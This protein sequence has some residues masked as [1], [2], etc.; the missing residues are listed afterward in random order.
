M[1]YL[2]YK[3][4]DARPRRLELE[5]RSY[6]LGRS[7]KN[8]L[9]LPDLSLSRRHA[10]LR[11]SGDG[12]WVV[13]DLGSKNGTFVDG[14]RVEGRHNARPG[15]VV[16]L[17]GSV[18]VIACAPLVAREQ[19]A[20]RTS[21][22]DWFVAWSYAALTFWEALWRVAASDRDVGVLLLGEM[23]TGKDL[24]KNDR[25][26]DV[27]HVAKHG[28]ETGCAGD[29]DDGH[30]NRGLLLRAGLPPDLVGQLAQFVVESFV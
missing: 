1:A 17:S 14:Q 8:D 10:E 4:A 16:R 6:T 13:E 23:G 20:A 26:T 24:A 2:T 28:G 12:G 11:P 3:G 25:L 9:T 27:V 29:G 7:S 21:P 19:I 18:F 22:P 15:Q 5:S 30:G